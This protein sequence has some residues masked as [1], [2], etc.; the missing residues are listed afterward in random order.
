MAEINTLHDLLVDELRDIFHAEKQI[1][2]ALPKMIKKATS[3]TLKAAFEKHLGETEGQIER[4]EKCFELLDE[5]ARA[6]PCAAMEGIIEEATEEMGEDMTDEVMDAVLIACAQKVEHYEIASY[7]SVI[8]WAT[9]LGLSE[10]AGLL[11][12][13]LDEE[14]ATDE[15]LTEL[16]DE[17]INPAA[18]QS[19]TEDGDEDDDEDDASNDDDDE[20]EEDDEDEEDAKPD[21][22][23]ADAKK[24]PAK[25]A[26]A[27]R[28]RN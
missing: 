25:A 12:E 13:T 21:T 10:V 6:K 16:A 15:A 17:E 20:E 1:T 5:K 28:K 24:A 3:P 26:P 2:K 14:K 7:G 8:A 4:I 11:T 23:K 22:K 18:L 19:E 9:G 27:S